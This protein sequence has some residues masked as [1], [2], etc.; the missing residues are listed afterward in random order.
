VTSVDPIGVPE[1]DPEPTDIR[2]GRS[3][4]LDD[5]PDEDAGSRRPCLSLVVTV[6]RDAMTASRRDSMARHPSA[7]RKD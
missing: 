2:S 4:S 6:G 3:C 5:D 7:D 1:P